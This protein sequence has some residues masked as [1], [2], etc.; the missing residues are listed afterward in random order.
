MAMAAARRKFN[1]KPFEVRRR[2]EYLTGNE[3]MAALERTLLLLL[4]FI[5]KLGRTQKKEIGHHGISGFIL[6]EDFCLF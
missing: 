1:N 5:R 4:T 2:E 6:N 3:L